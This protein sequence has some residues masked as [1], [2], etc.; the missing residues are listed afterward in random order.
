VVYNVRPLRLKDRAFGRD[1]GELDPIR[2]W[3]GY[4]ALVPPNS[5]PPASIVLAWWS[6][7]RCS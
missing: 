1:R 6:L 5:L 7:A 4:Y 2:L 3:L